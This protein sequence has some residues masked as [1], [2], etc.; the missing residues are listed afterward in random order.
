[1]NLLLDSHVFLWWMAD[2][3]RLRKDAKALIAD[4]DNSLAVS[5]ATMWEIT[6]KKAIGKLVAPD[7][8][9]AR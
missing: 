5:A 3:K 8:G 9:L 4:A 1:M 6:I 2:D 7:D